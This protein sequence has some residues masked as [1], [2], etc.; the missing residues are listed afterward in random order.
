MVW[1]GTSWQ[2]VAGRGKGCTGSGPLRAYGA[3]NGPETVRGLARLGT[4]GLGGARQGKAGAVTKRL[5]L[6]VGYIRRRDPEERRGNRGIWPT[7]WRKP[8]VSWA[9]F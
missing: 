4:A 1:Q 6:V 3:W 9:V 5:R 7:T 2:G 8:A